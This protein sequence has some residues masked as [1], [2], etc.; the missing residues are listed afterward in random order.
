MSLW[1]LKSFAHDS[2]GALTVHQSDQFWKL[3]YRWLDSAYQLY[4]R[5]GNKRIQSNHI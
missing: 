3:V 2:L 4:D 5:K 1:V